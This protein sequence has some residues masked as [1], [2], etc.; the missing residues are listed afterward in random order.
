MM[1]ALQILIFAVATAGVPGP[2]V[3]SY[4]D[5]AAVLAYV[6]DEGLVDYAGLKAERAPL[7]A[8]VASLDALDPAT[9]AAW[10]DPDKI[11]F[12]INAYN[13]LTLR[14]VVDH[15]PIAPAQPKPGFP[16]NSIG[17]IPG[18]WDQQQFRVLGKA[19]TLNQIE[20]EHLR[21]DFKEPRIH[22]ALV[23]AALSCPK[24]R[25]QP[26]R[27]ATLDD[28]LDDQAKT[29]LS[30]LTKLHI[31]RE[32]GEVWASRIFEWFAED[33]APP[34]SPAEEPIVT[35]RRAI[36][37]FAS[38]YVSEPDRKYL[39]TADFKVA[40]FEYDWTLNEPPR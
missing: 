3:P 9:Y 11:A 22:M 29:F 6:D 34:A 1:L 2:K 14:L 26:Y 38:K 8:F 28:Q 19:L 5:Y 39:E 16:K 35:R 21:K 32:S 36:V 37:T 23:C 31:D 20:H 24:L 30:D 33:F 10:S 18:V 17:Q 27:G 7:D 15:Y 40:F 12:W 25:K 4:D 13:A